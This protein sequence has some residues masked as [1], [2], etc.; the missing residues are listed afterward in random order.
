MAETARTTP[1][2]HIFKTQIGT[3]PNGVDLSNSVENEFYC[4]KLM[5]AF[6]LPVNAA[7]IKVFGKTKALVIERF[8]REWTKDGRLLR[9]PQEDF[10][11][12]ALMPT[13]PKISKRRRAGHD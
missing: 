11:P 5:A 9:I 3:L 7:E 4:L 12:G 13:R 10:L 1:T 2:T 8:D 6:G